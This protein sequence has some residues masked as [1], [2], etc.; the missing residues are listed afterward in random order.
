MAVTFS[1]NVLPFFVNHHQF[2]RVTVFNSK[3]EKWAMKKVIAH[4]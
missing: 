2:Y 1:R 4:V 3:C